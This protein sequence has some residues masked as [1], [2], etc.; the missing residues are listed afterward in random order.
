MLDLQVHGAA[1]ERTQRLPGRRGVQLE[2][3]VL[4][5]REPEV[6]LT[7]SRSQIALRR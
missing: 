3:H 6:N 7:V 4:A 1:D 5:I 2:A